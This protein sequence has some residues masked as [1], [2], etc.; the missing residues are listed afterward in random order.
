MTST[1]FYKRLFWITAVIV[2]VSSCAGRTKLESDL[3]IKG[4]PDWVNK[5]TNYVNDKDGRLFH[6]VG[7]AS[8]MGDAALQ[9]A[10]ADDRARA[11]LARIFS[12]YLDVVSSDYQ[13]AAKS[14]DNKVSQE[15]VSR[16][17]K[18][19]SK[20]NLTGA[21]I[22]ARWQDKKTNIVYSIAELDMKQVKG[23]LATS[24]D[25]NADLRR[26]VESNADNVF[27]RLNQEKK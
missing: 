9:R 11:E 5:G 1:N 10:T 21:K 17:V 23:T 19:L 13:S 18:N 20:V 26:Y 25:M 14:G 24:Q 15:A 27:D 8:A 3:A 22:V 2:A 16:Q 7:S 6:G 4:A 12:S